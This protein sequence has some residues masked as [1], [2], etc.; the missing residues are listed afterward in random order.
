MSDRKQ[1]AQPTGPPAYFQEIQKKARDRWDQLEGD[2][3]LA[4][5]WGQLFRQVQSPRHVVSELLQ[6]ADDAGARE[7]GVSVNDGEFVFWHDGEDFTREQFGSICRFAYSNKKTLH[8]IGFRGIGFKSTFSLG[9]EV[10]L[11]TPSL[12]VMFRKVRFTEPIWIADTPHPSRTEIRV[13]FRDQFQKQQLE[14]NLHEWLESPASLLF[15]QSVR[16]L[17]ITGHSIYWKTG[18][19]GP[20]PNS[21]RLYLYLDGGIKSVVLLIRSSEEML[22]QEAVEE[23]Q[24]ERGIGGE[25]SSEMPPVRFDIVLGLEGRLFVVLPTGVKTALPF[26]CNAP[27]IQDP[28]RFLI[29]D[30]ANSPTNR[31]LL[32]RIGHLAG[33]TMVAWLQRKDLALSDRAKAYELLSDINRTDTSLQGSVA[34]IVEL[35]FEVELSESDYFLTESGDVV[36]C[37]RCVEVPPQLHDIWTSQQISS[38]FDEGRRQLLCRLI[39]SQSRAKL[40]NWNLVAVTKDTVLNCLQANRLPR[41]DS[42][43]QLLQL[44][45]FVANDVCQPVYFGEN[46]RRNVCIFPVKSDGNLHSANEVVR[47]GEKRIL[48]SED[49]WRFLN[50]YFL[51]IDHEWLVFLS[52]QLKNADD[53][54]DVVLRKRME[55]VQ[56]ILDTLKLNLATDINRIIEIVSDRL[57][58]ECTHEDAIRIAQIAAKLSAPIPGTFRFITRNGRLTPANELILSDAKGVLDSL[59]EPSWYEGHCLAADYQS[60][61]HSCFEDD[62]RAWIESG[63][64][65][66]LSF[67]PLTQVKHSVWRREALKQF[68]TSRG[69]EAE[70]EFHY[71]SNTFRINDWDFPESQLKHWH[72]LA[73]SD[74]AV[75]AIVMSMVLRRSPAAWY[76]CT[77]ASVVH[78]AKNGSE[79]TILF[80][81]IVPAWISKFRGLP[82]LMDTNGVARKPH[83]LLRRTPATEALLEVELFLRAEDDTEANRPLLIQLG[84]NDKS[85]GPE[86]LIDRIC[87]LSLIMPFPETLIGELSKWYL[88]LDQQLS[89]CGTAELLS[90]KSAFRSRNLILTDK[91][92]WASPVNVFLNASESDVPNAPLIHPAFR[93]LT[94]WTRIGVAERPTVELALNWLKTLPSG[95]KLEAADVRR[96]SALLQKLPDKVWQQTGHWLNLEREWVPVSTLPYSLSMRTLIPWSNLFPQVK[97]KTADFMSLGSDT[98]SREPFSQLPSLASQIAEVSGKAIHAVG[99]LCTQPWIEELGRGFSRIRL[100]DTFAE[101]VFRALGNRLART[102]WQVV[103]SLNSEPQIN[104]VPAGTSRPRDVFWNDTTLFVVDKPVPS[105]SKA[106]AQEISRVSDHPDISDAVLYCIER[107]ADSIEKYLA[108]S[109][110]LAP[111]VL[112]HRVEIEKTPSAPVIPSADHSA[113][114]FTTSADAP[115][116]LDT[117][118]DSATSP[119]PDFP[120]LQ[121]VPPDAPSPIALMDGTFADHELEEPSASDEKPTRA[122][123]KRE[124]RTSLIETYAAALGYRKD[125]DG[126]R[127]VHQDGGWIQRTSE[128]VFPWQRFTADGNLAQSFWAKEG[129]LEKEPLAIDAAIWNLLQE[130]PDSY[131]I[132]L[133][134]VDESLSVLSG[135]KLLQLRADNL[136]T[137]YAANYRLVYRGNDVES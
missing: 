34:T 32:E 111:V 23:I 7:A 13:K 82:C 12:A 95:Q 25:E 86:K 68:L 109:F 91:L 58:E 71:R 53:D 17:E 99:P 48:Q 46:A 33:T 124:S 113:H 5:P 107:P 51:T 137:L 74:P 129:C 72:C 127:F 65:R 121:F 24:E 112:G 120:E 73:K 15:F 96:V 26:A 3:E 31:W 118:P 27:F 119:S 81:S 102:K 16:K 98:C 90:A 56:R 55:A 128:S 67:V 105:L 83:E 92:D 61:F 117:N 1:L 2:P 126:N 44:W 38:L 8:T 106:I 122:A 97:R 88:R 39:D 28:A 110:R 11:L 29:K 94:I 114:N 80:Q 20:V 59:I 52:V 115:T 62:W 35:A 75:W 22:P 37:Q 133:R 10:Q 64:S 85:R 101:E 21:N 108:S 93:H 103:A 116:P 78:I 57:G 132:L 60:K 19:D 14:Q 130:H 30:P 41:P 70:P 40:L 134:G 54:K 76:N 36:D 131:S 69:Y 89:T 104:G 123:A 47:I 136:L 125:G 4:G 43:P 18:A 42:W 63:K 84:V 87:G 100:D 135:K 50:E 9:D 66:L 77:S 49:D 45:L 79:R 6:N